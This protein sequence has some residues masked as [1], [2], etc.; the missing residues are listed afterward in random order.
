M[1]PIL[2]PLPRI[3]LCCESSC[4]RRTL[5]NFSFFFSDSGYPLVAPPSQLEGRVRSSPRRRRRRYHRPTA[6]SRTGGHRSPCWQPFTATAHRIFTAKTRLIFS[7]ISLLLLSRPS[8]R[9][10]FKALFFHTAL[11]GYDKQTSPQ[12]GLSPRQ[13]NTLAS[14]YLWHTRRHKFPIVDYLQDETLGVRR[15]STSPYGRIDQLILG[16]SADIDLR[17]DEEPSPSHMASNGGHV[18]VAR[19]LLKHCAD[20]EIRDKYDCLLL[21]R[22]LI[23]G[24]VAV[25]WVL[26]KKRWRC[27]VFAS[28]KRQVAVSRVEHG[29]DVNAHVLT[30]R[31][32]I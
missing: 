15:I 12:T 8:S 6:T 26:L 22:V 14:C 21:Q 30:T 23:E 4:T 7:H 32:Y 9:L 28:V 5:T 17:D 31:P 10:S 13:G 24:R 11:Q 25:A 16:N 29:A 27:V 2:L 18:E 19:V 3:V 1:P 20:R